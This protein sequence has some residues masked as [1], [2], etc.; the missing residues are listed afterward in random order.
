MTKF[1][2]IESIQVMVKSVGVAG[3]ALKERCIQIELR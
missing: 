2:S 3:N 1:K